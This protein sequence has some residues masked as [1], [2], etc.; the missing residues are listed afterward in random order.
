MMPKGG[1]EAD[2][3][4][5]GLHGGRGGGLFMARVRWGGGRGGGR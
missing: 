5:Q 2:K 3:W 1:A 4:G